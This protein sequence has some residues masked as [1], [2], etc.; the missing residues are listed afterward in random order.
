MRFTYIIFF[1]LI[2]NLSFS[3]IYGDIATDKRKVV[4]QIDY[5]FE[6]NYNGQFVFDIVVDE[7]GNV[8]SCKLNQAKSNI[9][10][11]PT[12]MQAKNMVKRLKFEAGYQFPQFH[13]G[14]VV[15]KVY[16]GDNK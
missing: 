9:V 3:Q 12:M 5:A 10:S 13:R 8:T 11:T 15:I 4:K 1:L 16:K 7:K 2:A 6:G 14:E